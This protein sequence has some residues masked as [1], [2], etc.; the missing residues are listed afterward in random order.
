MHELRAHGAPG[1]DAQLGERGRRFIIRRE[2]AVPPQP[3]PDGADPARL[4]AFVLPLLFD[5]AEHHD[6]DA[7][8][9]T[10]DRKSTRLNSS[11]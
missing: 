3:S 5:T 10:R 8:P 4:A 7:L 11:H 9:L 6:G 2:Q 1:T